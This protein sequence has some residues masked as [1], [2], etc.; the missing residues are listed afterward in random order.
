[1]LVDAHAHLDFDEFSGEEAEAVARAQ[2]AGVGRIVNVGTT[3]ERSKASVA[4]ADRFDDVWATVGVHPHDA[5]EVTDEVVTQLH[6]LTQQPKVVA[7][8]EIGF[9]FHYEKGPTEK[10]QERAFLHQAAI[11]G[12][13]D[14]PIIVHSR[15]AEA[16]TIRY[17]Q[18]MMWNWKRELPGVVHCFTGTQAFAEVALELGF[19]ISF[20]APITYPKNDALREVV[21]KVPLERILVETDC[22]FLAPKDKRGQRNEPAY[23]VSTA[24]KVA[25]LKQVSFEEVAKQTT[26]NAERLFGFGG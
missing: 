6:D 18:R 1:M 3:L 17:L 16:T 22:P 19:F 20:T 12:D 26:E 23:V 21:K 15:D 4:L 7:V 5:A 9:D 13:R 8:G 24:K 14:L 10:Q 25:E 2:G 11:A